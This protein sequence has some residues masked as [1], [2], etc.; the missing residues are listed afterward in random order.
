MDGEHFYWYWWLIQTRS[1]VGEG[2]SLHYLAE[3]FSCRQAFVI[4]KPAL[5]ISTHPNWPLEPCRSRRQAE[6]EHRCYAQ[7]LTR[8]RTWRK[9]LTSFMLCLVKNDTVHEWASS[10]N[11]EKSRLQPTLAENSGYIES[12]A[13]WKGAARHVQ[14]FVFIL[15]SIWNRTKYA[16]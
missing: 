13:C 9:H 3:V 15:I 6:P 1:Y 10:G 2:S 12:I 11:V 7:K 8:S 4:W 5:R 14:A 16:F